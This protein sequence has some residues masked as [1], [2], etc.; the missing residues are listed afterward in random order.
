MRL[1]QDYRVNWND[2]DPNFHLRAAVCGDYAVNTQYL[3]L[4]QHGS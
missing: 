4:E 3:W 2:L 1:L